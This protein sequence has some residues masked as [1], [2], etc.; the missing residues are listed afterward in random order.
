MSTGLR[1][2]IQQALAEDLGPGDV[3]TEATVPADVVGEGQFKAKQSLVVCGHAPARMVF[4]VLAAD[5]EQQVAYQIVIPDGGT[6]SSGDVVARVRG[7]LSLLITG[8]RLA[9]N[10]MMRLSG[11]ATNTRLYVDAAGPDGPAVVDTRKTTPLLRDLEK[12]AVRAGGGRNHR[13]ALYDGVLIKDNHVTAAGGVK[14]A[15]RAARSRA[16][17]LLRIE[18]EVSDQ[19]Q[20]NEALDERAEV[21][22]L[23]NM[24][25]ALLAE[26]IRVARA[27]DSRVL[28]EASGNMNPERIARIKGFGMDFVSAGGLV[29][30]ARWVDLSMKVWAL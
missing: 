2:F 26:A 24:D 3:T 20:L 13:H 11:V 16:H 23:D 7:P 17:H 14:P 19:A 29:H 28:L 22:L 5:R 30:Q 8:E 4:E 27:R 25:D 9:L 12:M 18:V 15:I 1:A 6:A 10:L 21:I